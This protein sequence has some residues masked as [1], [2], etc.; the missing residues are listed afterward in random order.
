MIESSEAEWQL[1]RR[2]LCQN[3]MLSEKKIW[4]NLR[5]KIGWAGSVEKRGWSV[6]PQAKETIS[7]RI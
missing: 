2:L 7:V 1:Q 4:W 5:G 3:S 6:C